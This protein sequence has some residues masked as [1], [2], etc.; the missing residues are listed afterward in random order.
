MPRVRSTSP[1]RRP[2]EPRRPREAFTYVVPTP[3]ITAVSPSSGP[4]RGRDS[5][6][7]HGL[8]LRR[9]GDGVDRRGRRHVRRRRLGDVDH[10]R[11]RRA[12]RGPGRRRRHEPGRRPG[13]ASGG[14]R[15][16]RRDRRASPSTRSRPAASSTRG[17]PTGRSAAPSS[18]R[19]R[20]NG[21]SPSRRRAAS[22]P[23]QGSFRPTSP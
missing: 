7:D 16:H 13:N 12:C 3:A 18:R 19:H 10:R 17:T 15:V 8:R 23:T 6:H 21:P 20:P 22:R 4:S 1:S 9:R 5:R 11:D 2:A 14:L